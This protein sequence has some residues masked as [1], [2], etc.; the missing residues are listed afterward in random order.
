MYMIIIYYSSNF[1]D[2]CIDKYIEH[3]LTFGIV[4]VFFVCLERAYN[5]FFNK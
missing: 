5:K 2:K 3:L 1:I 4:I